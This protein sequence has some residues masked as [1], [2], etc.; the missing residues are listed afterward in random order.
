MA[1]TVSKTGG[2][3]VSSPEKSKRPLAPYTQA[4]NRQTLAAERFRRRSAIL[5]DTAGLD[6]K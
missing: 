6:S 1:R 3:Q 2:H 5:W 4:S